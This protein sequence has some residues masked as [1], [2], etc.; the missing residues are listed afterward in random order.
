MKVVTPEQAQGYRSATIAGGLKGAGLGFGIAIPAHFLLQRRAAYRAVP[1]TLKTLGYVCL[2]VPLISIAAEKS[3]EAYDRSQWTGVGARE[4]ERSR[5]KEERR[6]ED[7]SSSQ[8][9]RD[10]AARNKWGLIAGSWAGSMA[11]A[12]AIVARTPQT[13][14]QKLVQAR[15]WAQGLTVGTLISSALLAGVTSEDKV[16]QPRVDHSW[17]DMLEQE[18]QMKK[19]EIAALRRAADAE[20]ARRSQAETQRA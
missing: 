8:K 13:F 2:L 9:V 6:W 3:G 18:G 4:L 7:L 19:S 5:D 10:W 12:F 20:Y 1:I 11:I 15:M 17:V 16:I 14:S